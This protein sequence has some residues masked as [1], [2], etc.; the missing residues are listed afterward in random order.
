MRP[1]TLIGHRQT[2]VPT[3]SDGRFVRRTATVSVTVKC[4]LIAFEFDLHL[5][6]SYRWVMQLQVGCIRRMG[7]AAGARKGALGFTL[8]ELLV[9][10][11]IIATLVAILLPVLS[12]AR[13]SAN[14]AACLSNVRSMEIAQANY[15]ADNRGYLI[16]AGFGHGSEQDDDQIAWFNTL[17]H[18]YQNKLVAR[19][20]SD[21]SPY[22]ESYVPSSS[23]PKYRQT[24]YCINDF[25][26]GELYCP[27][28][29]GFTIP[30]PPNAL[31]VKISRV[32]RPAATIQF[33]E[34]TYAGDFAGADHCHVEDWVSNV[35]NSASKN[36]QTNAHGGHAHK[37]DAVSNYGF[38][39]GHAESLRFSDVFT[40]FY[41]N[42]FD[43][44]IAQ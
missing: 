5:H 19:C 30:C 32:P 2:I 39:D 14:R 11:G 20:P 15:I 22:W 23:P 21:D 3:V 37:A 8:V 33:A 4:N 16:F 31:Y 29:P 42:K 17:Q 26:A 34:V 36:L 28:G 41:R 13:Q 18:Y 40:D 9:V 25:V 27:W 1:R 35:P 12:K 43:P 7:L 38:L 24:S 10:V 44:A 6:P